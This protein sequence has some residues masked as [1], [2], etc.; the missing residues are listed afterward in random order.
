[1]NSEKNH[2]EKKDVVILKAVMGRWDIR[3]TLNPPDDDPQK[4]MT[5]RHS[6]KGLL[7]AVRKKRPNDFDHLKKMIE[8]AD[9]TVKSLEL[10][11]NY[12]KEREYQKEMEKIK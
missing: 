12:E 10:I 3:Y 11:S 9:S 2:D 7:M 5:E 8:S 6:I 1:M 4:E